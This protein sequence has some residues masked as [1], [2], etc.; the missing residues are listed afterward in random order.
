MYEESHFWFIVTATVR[1]RRGR[2]MGDSWVYEMENL[3]IGHNLWY[4][5]PKPVAATRTSADEGTS[6]FSPDGTSL[7][8]MLKRGIIEL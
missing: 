6:G 4:L 7:L 1:S 3:K 5:K 8:P 2:Y